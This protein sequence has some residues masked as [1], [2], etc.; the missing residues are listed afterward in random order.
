MSVKQKSE[1]QIE[2]SYSTQLIK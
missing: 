2:N 1:N